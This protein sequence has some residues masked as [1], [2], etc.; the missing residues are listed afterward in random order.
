MNFFKSNL[1][2]I[3]GLLFGIVFFLPALERSYSYWNLS[4]LKL[5]FESYLLRLKRESVIGEKSFAVQFNK[6]TNESV[7]VYQI[8]PNSLCE[9]AS[10]TKQTE[11]FKLE[12]SPTKKYVIEA[13][14]DLIVCF[15]ASQDPKFYGRSDLSLELKPTFDSF[16]NNN[17]AGT[18]HF[19]V[20]VETLELEH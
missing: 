11:E 6:G 3:L 14:V 2:L 12:V 4:S 19:K 20:L 8:E 18:I 13:Q 15:F 1:G 9:P 17:S 5:S 16:F 7:K 10:L